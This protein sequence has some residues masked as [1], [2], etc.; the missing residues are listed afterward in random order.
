MWSQ[1]YYRHLSQLKSACLLSPIVAGIL[2]FLHQHHF[3]ISL[4]LHAM[5]IQ[6][7]S[8]Q[9]DQGCQI[10]LIDEQREVFRK[11]WATMDLPGV[12]YLQVVD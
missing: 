12:P 4:A 1:S 2:E 9:Y 7:D 10:V 5:I 3:T 11:V 6:A 8:R